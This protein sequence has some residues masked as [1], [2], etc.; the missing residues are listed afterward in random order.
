MRTDEYVYRCLTLYW[1]I[2]GAV[3]MLHTCL[4]LS[5]FQQMI[6]QYMNVHVCTLYTCMYLCART[7]HVHVDSAY[8]HACT[9][10]YE[11]SH[12]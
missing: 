1:S 12:E 7:I 4:L 11:P 6:I 10:V 8:V 9:Y 5:N 2:H 3:G